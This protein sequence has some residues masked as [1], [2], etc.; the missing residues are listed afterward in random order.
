MSGDGVTIPGSPRRSPGRGRDESTFR[1][2]IEGLG[3]QRV[4]Y[5]HYAESRRLVY[6]SSGFEEIF[7]IPRGEVLERPWEEVIHWLP[8]T[9][10]RGMQANAALYGG[11]TDRLELDM[12]FVHPDGDERT[13]HIAAR[14]T[15]DG[16]GTR[17]IDGVVEDITGKQR[18]E[19]D[20]RRERAVL[21]ALLDQRTSDLAEIRQAFA[22]TRRARSS[23]L[24]SLSY[25]L[26]TPLSS[27]LGFSTI[28]QRE[29]EQSNDQRLF[30]YFALIHQ[31]GTQLLKLFESLAEL[32]ELE[33]GIDSYDMSLLDI[34]GLVRDVTEGVHKE[35]SRK[36]LD[37]IVA[38]KAEDT[39]AWGDQA[40]LYKALRALLSQA[41]EYSPQD[42]TIK[43]LIENAYVAAPGKSASLTLSIIDQGVPLHDDEIGGVF[44][45]LD[46]AS[47][48]RNRTANGGVSLNFAFCR[49]VV[50]DH[51]GTIEAFNN[52]G[53]GV[54]IRM[55]IPRGTPGT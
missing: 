10:E 37:V 6:L 23:L 8:E 45:G 33:A 36:R 17:M 40:K 5:S 52:D 34:A 3:E 7:G 50:N 21:Q 1:R 49:R 26:R 30:E 22:E 25:E 2:L 38:S 31:E 16:N 41:I 13:V 12:R 28:G 11:T 35:W 15:M 46:Q 43:I 55:T 27:I 18:N 9:L 39:L 4:F 53:R 19:L 54:C 29:T 20:A 24:A 44:D 47:I 48:T 14:A 32:Y 42:A 51:G